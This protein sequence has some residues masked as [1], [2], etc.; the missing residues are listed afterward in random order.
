MIELRT[1][2]ALDL[3]GCDPQNVAALFSQPK[4]LALLA[5]LAIASPRGF[6]RRDSLLALFWPES[7]QAHARGALRNALSFLRHQLGEAVVATRGDEVGLDPAAF[8]CDATAF[9]TCADAQQAEETLVLY[10]GD[11]LE[12]FHLSDAPDFERWLDRERIRLRARAAEAAWALAV[13]EE[14]AGNWVSA[15]GH[16]RRAVILS[17]DYEQ[18]SCRLI[19]LLDRAGDRAAALQE[20]E[21]LQRRL[22]DELEVPPSPETRSLIEAIRA[23]ATPRNTPASRPPPAARPMP[24]PAEPRAVAGPGL[25]PR[26]PIALGF[27]IFFVLSGGWILWQLRHLPANPPSPTRIAIF[28]FTVRGSPE[29]AYL[30]EGIVDLLTANLDGLGELRIVDSRAVL[31]R[32]SLPGGSAT[33]PRN[34]GRAAVGLG[35]GAYVVGEIVEAGG[36]L[37]ISARFH[38]V[39]RPEEA[40]VLVTVEG[41]P[42]GIFELVDSLAG[43]LVAGHTE[44]S[45]RGF[46]RLAAVTTSSLPALKV[47]LDGEGALR[48]GQHPEAIEAFQQATRLDTTFALAYYGLA[49]AAT[50][51]RSNPSLVYAASH[52]SFVYRERL[53]WRARRLIE[54]FDARIH[55]RHAE[56]EHLY[57]EILAAYPNQFEAWLGLGG[58]LFFH[59]AF[60]GRSWAE[61]R[62]AYEQAAALDPRDA[63]P[64]WFLTYIAAREGRL[65]EL[66]SLTDRLLQL[67]PGAFTPAALV[68][69]GQ[70]AVLR[71]DTVEV[72]RF[73]ATVEGYSAEHLQLT[74]GMVTWTTGDIAMG[75]RLW[76]LVAD[77]SRSSGMRALA[78]MT[79]AKLE[80]TA[81]RWHAAKAQL[82]SL[83][84]IDY[85]TGIEH[86]AYFALTRFLAVPRSELEAMRDAVLRWD[87]TAPGSPDTTGLFR[88]HG[89][90]HPYLRLYLL[91]LLNARM[92]DAAAALSYATELQKQSPRSHAPT[93][94][95][96]LGRVV[97]MEVAWAAGRLEEAL[98]T[99]E[100]AGFWTRLDS[101]SLDSPFLERSYERFGRAELLNQLGRGEAAARWYRPMVDGFVY[102]GGPSALRLAQLHD[103]RGKPQQA[104]EYYARFLRWWQDCDPELRPLVDEARKRLAE[105]PL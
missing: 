59:G 31:S 91:G 93:F 79:L 35:A 99:L 34:L 22:A 103:R 84:A 77:R 29:F 78:H 2:G 75:R 60:L 8:W 70:R 63:H 10:R 61:A 45:A 81:G 17:P 47:Y 66:D 12:G 58:I 13:V 41:S 18:A 42:T 27:V 73:V 64:L 95:G 67:E 105:I 86:R 15:A 1:L 97:R 57:R 24:K 14:Q 53:G 26:R 16:A 9:E 46:A 69:R 100:G 104:R 25:R 11:L 48:A 102:A 82:D 74:G 98:S 96:D 76:G 28:P 51:W 50:W 23:R 92:G 94:V 39:E 38:T 30:R 49:R 52:R 62:I 72:E 5:Y 83:Q 33:I 89:K 4:R 68:A 20:Y 7:D 36:R 32:T 88:L 56:A 21:T 71:G 90:L 101:P 55:Q 54:A 37:R 85:S 6:H 87:A 19:E 43:Q 3:R 80:V 44:S 40:T 65:A